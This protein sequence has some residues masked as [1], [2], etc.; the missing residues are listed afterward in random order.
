MPRAMFWSI[1][2]NGILAFVM[3]IMILIS[4][5]SIEDTLNAA[6]PIIAVLSK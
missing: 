5:G 4:M 3:I 6:H 2:M 1:V